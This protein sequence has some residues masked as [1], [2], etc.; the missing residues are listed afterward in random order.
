[1]LDLFRCWSPLLSFSAA[2]IL[3]LA[4]Y[5]WVMWSRSRF[6]RLIDALPGPKP[7]PLLGNLFDVANI[8]LD[9]ISIFRYLK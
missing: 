9:G 1:M 2:V 7:L 4:G 6:V 5:Y 3:L 8:P